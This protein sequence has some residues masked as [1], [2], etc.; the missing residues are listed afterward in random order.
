MTRTVAR[1]SRSCRPPLAAPRAARLAQG[2]FLPLS[3]TENG[4]LNRNAPSASSLVVSVTTTWRP[5]AIPQTACHVHRI[6]DNGEIE[7]AGRTRSSHGSLPRRSRLHR[8][9]VELAGG[10]RTE[11]DD[12]ECGGARAARGIGAREDGDD[13]SPTNLS[14]SPPLSWIIA[15]CF[16]TKAVQ[17]VHDLLG[18]AALGI[19]GKT[20]H[21]REKKST[22]NTLRLLAFLERTDGARRDILCELEALVKPSNHRIHRPTENANLVIPF[23]Y[24]LSLEIPRRD[25][26]AKPSYRLNRLEYDAPEKVAAM[27]KARMVTTARN[28]IPASPIVTACALITPVTSLL[29]SM[30]PRTVWSAPWQTVHLGRL[31]RGRYAPEVGG[32]PANTGPS[33]SLKNSSC[34]GRPAASATGASAWSCPAAEDD[35][36]LNR[37]TPRSCSPAQWCCCLKTPSSRPAGKALW[38]SRRL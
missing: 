3:F 26:G 7:R 8:Q 22:R 1:K 25:I 17:D 9:T 16:W 6:T 37:C 23:H 19:G 2:W 36:W 10:F 27:M 18:T 34:G 21:I 28:P 31:M 30:T 14:M 5:F 38:M 13:L 20:S 29:M 4:P 35:P 24:D 33:S 11:T 32:P 15:D 12:A